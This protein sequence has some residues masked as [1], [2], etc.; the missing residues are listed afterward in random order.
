MF[1]SPSPQRNNIKVSKFISFSYEKFPNP[2][3]PRHKF[4]ISFYGAINVLLEYFVD[5]KVREFG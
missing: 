3:Y 2:L 1:R 5:T 4:S